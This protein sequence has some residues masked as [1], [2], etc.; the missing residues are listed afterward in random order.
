MGVVREAVCVVGFEGVVSTKTC[1][2]QWLSAKEGVQS[3]RAH[4]D[5]A[6]R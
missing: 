2:G 1:M 6:L 3:G 5:S 4:I